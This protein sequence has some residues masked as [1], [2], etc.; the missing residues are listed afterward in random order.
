MAKVPVLRSGW[1]IDPA[2]LAVAQERTE[3]RLTDLFTHRAAPAGR[4]PGPHPPIVVDGVEL[5]GD[6]QEP[7]NLVDDDPTLVDPPADERSDVAPEPPVADLVG[8]VDSPGIDLVSVMVPPPSPRGRV[9]VMPWPDPA[10]IVAH[11]MQ[12]TLADGPVAAPVSEAVPDPDAFADEA[13]PWTAATIDPEPWM[14]ATVES[15]PALVSEAIVESEPWME[16]TVEPEPM[17]EAIDESEPILASDAAATVLPTEPE[18]FEEVVAGP[19][20]F[21]DPVIV[22][23]PA[24]AIEL[25]AP[26]ARIAAEPAPHASIIEMPEVEPV[27]AATSR[28]PRVMK[29][30][31]TPSKAGKSRSRAATPRRATRKPATA[32]GPAP[33]KPATAAGPAPIKPATAAGPAPVKPATP[34]PATAGPPVPASVKPATASVRPATVPAPVKAGGSAA[35]AARRPTAGPPAPARVRPATPKPATVAGLATAKAASVKPA[36]AAA[37]TPAPVKAGGSAAPAARRPTAGPPVPAA[38]S[39]NTAGPASAPVAAADPAAPVPAAASANTAGPASAPVAAADPTAPV[40]VSAPVKAAGP[41]AP[42]ARRPAAPA[43]RRPMAGPPAPTSAPVK[44]AGPTARVPASA[45]AAV[46]VAAACPYC[47]LLLQPPPTSSRRCP[48]CRQ[49]IVVKHIDGRTAYLTEA[50]IAIF[51]AERRK[52]SDVGRLTRER[53]RWLKLAVAAGAPAQRASRLGA[54]RLS[55]EVVDE[56]RQ[57]YLGTVDR[58][59]AA[60]KR[61]RRWEEAARIRREQAIALHRLAGSPQPPPDDLLAIYQEGVAA[62]LR[63]LAEIVRDAELVSAMCCDP[64]RA[65]NGRIAQITKELAAPQMPHQGC[66]KVFCRCTWDL[67]TRDRELVLRYLRRRPRPAARSAART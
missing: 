29:T 60:A 26:L 32:A 66:P 34:K 5:I 1:K 10:P 4:R 13:E 39:A 42:A 28:P 9:G 54:A 44:A 24:V 64:C 8:V 57:L 37:P 35:P 50:A 23:D 11:P 51:E 7:L 43:A 62:E 6:T 52:E 41:A 47:A 2:E 61:D 38:A 36:T 40:P 17:V 21:E 59:F 14:A 55:Q 45:P 53:E 65:D 15:E 46:V 12:L 33:V 63:G 25:P 19:G 18:P 27:V 67:A 31:A 49:Q 16:D 58:T 20:L 56:S 22:A 3:A 48:R 30:G